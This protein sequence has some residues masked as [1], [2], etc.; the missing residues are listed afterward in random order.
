MRLLTCP[1]CTGSVADTN[2][3]CPDCGAPLDVSSSPT[4]TALGRTPPSLRPVSSSAGAS[5]TAAAQ[6]RFVP[7][8]VLAGR[9]RVAGLLGR[10]GM[11]EVYRADDL[12]LG[13]AVAL[14]FLPESLQHDPDRLERFFNGV[15]MARQVTHPA[16]CRVHDVGEAEGQQFL[17]MEFVD[18]EDLASLQRRI[19]RL[20]PDKALQIARQLCAGLGAAHEKGVLHRDLKPENVMLDGRGMARITDFDLAQ[21]ADAVDPADVR[22]GTPAYM[23]PEQLEGREVTARSDIYALGL[24]L[25]ELFTGRRPFAGR[26]FSELRRARQEPPPP[27]STFVESIDPAVEQA[28]LRCLEA[29]PAR[30]PAS[31]PAVA[32]ALPGGDP[33]AAA[34]AA[35]QTPSPELVAASGRTEGLTAPLA[36]AALATVAL[37]VALAPVVNARFQLF[38]RVPFEKPPAAL[39]DRARDL[40]ARMGHADPAADSAVGFAVDAEYV[41]QVEATDRSPH[42]WDSLSIGEPP[43]LLFW[44]RQSPRSL[45]STSPFGRVSSQNPALAVSGMAGVRLDMRGRLAEFYSIPPQVAEAAPAATPDWRPLFAE[46]GLD[47]ARFQATS[48]QWTPPFFCDTR[49]A[50]LG[51]YAHRP[52]VPVR[53]EAA[54]YGG[55]PVYFIIVAPWT[56]PERMRAFQFRPGQQAASTIGLVLL[57]SMIA[58]AAGLARRNVRLGRGDRRGALRLAAYGFVAAVVFWALQADH[59]AE[60][61]PEVGL[62]VTGVALCLLIAAVIW[63]L[64]LALEPYARRRW[65]ASLVAW[66]RLLSGRLA[67]PL[68]GRDILIGAAAGVVVA[69][70]IPL[71]LTVSIRFGE[72]ALRPSWDA[73]DTFLGL[74]MLASYAIGVQ[75]QAAASGIILFLLLLI[76]RLLLR[77]EWL[78]V[79]V[80][81][82]FLSLQAA[83]SMQTAW[84]VVVLLEGAAVGLLLVVLV[85]FGLLAMIAFQY[86]VA[87]LGLPLTTELGSWRATPTLFVAALVLALAVHGFRAALA[88]RPALVAIP[89]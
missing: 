84:W 29:D 59:V 13:Q 85:R 41:Q 40:L 37:G 63:L 62:I 58:A 10:G 72:P 20:P 32:A 71:A 38:R 81:L 22:S 80:L 44:Y 53:V 39:E 25:Y 19:G 26:T 24:V 74:R 27:P 2:R 54:G 21:A 70:V 76:L 35:G 5:V 83:L 15:R 57:L 75:L 73:L 82:A 49:A 33:L 11:G 89:D 66:T 88:G 65:P 14:K 48:P 77:R 87:L 34:L 12:R 86:V 67:D 3:F 43:V 61:R 9:Y 79:V 8:A 68:V 55:R 4:R 69:V 47:M 60:L 6:A 56:R 42:R 31:V 17:T 16:V 45:V 1:A 23:S 78:A 18:G 36:W 64:Y 51:S 52:G 50:W 46:A 28:I 7:G 30:R